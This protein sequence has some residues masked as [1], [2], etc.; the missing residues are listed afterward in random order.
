MRD[1]T[2]DLPIRFDQV[3]FTAGE[4]RIL[5]GVTLT[6]AIGPPTVV[7]GPNGSG[8]TTLLK[9]AMGLLE[10]TQGRITFAE[11]PRPINR[12]RAFVFQ[13]PMMLRRSVAKNAAYALKMAGSPQSQEKVERLLDQVGL[14]LVLNF[15]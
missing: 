11:Q 14:G 15:F 13:K 4:T 5:N 2:S 8:K 3:A 12:R 10:P 6:F 1:Q 9:L 7:L